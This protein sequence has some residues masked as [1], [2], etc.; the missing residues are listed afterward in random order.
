MPPRYAPCALALLLASSSALAD[1]DWIEVD[2]IAIV[3][4]H[5]IILASEVEL[6]VS[7]H[8]DVTLAADDAAR[9]AKRVEVR[10]AVIDQLIEKRLYIQKADA[11]RITVDDSDIDAAI[12]EIKKQ[13]ALD[14]AGLD[15]ALAAQS[16]TMAEYKLELHYQL[17][18][19]RTINQL[20]RPKVMVR[21]AEVRAEY[22]RLVNGAGSGG[23]SFDDAKADI[24]AQLVNAALEAATTNQLATWRADTYVD[25]RLP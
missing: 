4:D 22:D 12:D 9:A 3:V 13:N 23:K 15:A 8:P 6:E 16:W 21:D 19:L 18:R 17:L 20:I 5:D 2:R 24:R 11:A 1:T 10:P 25:V 7:R 14:D